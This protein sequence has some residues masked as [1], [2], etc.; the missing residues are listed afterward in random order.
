MDEGTGTIKSVDTGGRT[1]II[2]EDG[3]GADLEFMNPRIPGVIEGDRY[4]FFKII[5]ST[6]NGEVVVNILKTKMPR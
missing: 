5:Q 6:P 3:S 2:T 4:D 1:G